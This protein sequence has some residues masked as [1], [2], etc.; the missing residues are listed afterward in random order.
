MVVTV[1]V[2]SKSTLVGYGFQ[3]GT[4]LPEMGTIGR[5]ECGLASFDLAITK[6]NGLGRASG[7]LIGG[8]LLTLF[9]LNAHAEDAGEA[10][11][12]T[13]SLGKADPSSTFETICRTLKRSAANNNLPIEF[14]TQVIWQESRFDVRAHSSA[15]AQ[16]I[17][18]FMPQTASSRGL[19]DPF[20]PFQSLICPLSGRTEKPIWQFR[21][22]CGCLQCGAGPGLPLALRKGPFTCGNYCLR[23][24]RHRTTNLRVDLYATACLGAHGNP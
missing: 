17:A 10:V 7:F 20:D 8:L 24:H 4:L 18:Q 21:I 5:S 3:E 9:A 11:R 2:P 13:Q 1:L 16:G 15:G 19:L 23:S 22:S 12:S 14:F 6:G